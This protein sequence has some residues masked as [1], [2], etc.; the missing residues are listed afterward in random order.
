MV[1]RVG[2]VCRIAY[3]TTKGEKR[4]KWKRMCMFVDIA[5]LIIL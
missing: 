2:H 3:Y 4:R 5:N 1:R